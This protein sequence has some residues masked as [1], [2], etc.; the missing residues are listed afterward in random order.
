MD[1]DKA[2]TEAT[3]AK[4]FEDFMSEI[5]TDIISICLEYVEGKADKIYIYCSF[6]GEVLSCDFFY[7]IN[8]NI[9]RKHELNTAVQTDT[10]HYDTSTARQS[11]VFD[12][13]FE[14]M[15]KIYNLCSE[16]KRPMWSEI[17]MIYDVKANSVSS[18][19]NY[20]LVR[21]NNIDEMTDTGIQWYEEIKKDKDSMSNVNR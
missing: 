20:D 10:F 13:I 4:A 17:K 9:V 8:N 12:V 15:E 2:C 16:Y 6:D 7:Q 14:D 21:S 11:A 18:N 1:W 19:F 5:L 3:M